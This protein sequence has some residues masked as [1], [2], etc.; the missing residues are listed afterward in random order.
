MITLEVI[1]ELSSKKVSDQTINK[2]FVLKVICGFIMHIPV[3]KGMQQKCLSLFVLYTEP[4]KC[5]LT[6]VIFL[7]MLWVKILI[8]VCIISII[9]KVISNSDSCLGVLQN[10]FGV[11]LIVESDKYATVLYKMYFE[12]THYDQS[13]KELYMKCEVSE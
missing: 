5:S 9:A 3:T 12:C 8:Y 2:K 11:I 1:D 10:A 6:K 13:S 4:S 7:V